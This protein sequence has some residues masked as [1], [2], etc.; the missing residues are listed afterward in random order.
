VTVKS[1]DAKRVGRAFSNRATE[2]LLGSFPGI[3]TLNPPGDAREFG[4]YW[5]ALI[6]AEAIETIVVAPD[7]TRIA[8][9]ARGAV[10][11][12]PL[13]L[14][15]PPRAASPAG[16]T[17]LL[18]LGTVF[19]ARSGDKGGNANIGVWARSDAGYAWLEDFLTAQRFRELV[20]DCAELAVRRFELPNLRA[21]NFV[22]VGLLGEGVTSSTR[23]DP[24][25]KGLGEFL[26]S[27]LVPLPVS[28][29]GAAP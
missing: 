7:G 18:P 10:A 4:V 24:Q 13:E 29:L 23:Q 22:A 1:R 16:E 11:S 26:R 5:P 12:D 17:R 3:F 20:P 6:P 9:P 19:G 25:A 2:M 28:L 21:L 15:C 8:L 14:P 27:R